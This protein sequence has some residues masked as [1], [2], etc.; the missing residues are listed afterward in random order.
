MEGEV[1]TRLLSID[2]QHR[3]AHRVEPRLL[4]R[5]N[6]YMRETVECGP[7]CNRFRRYAHQLAA[8]F[9]LNRFQKFVEA[10]RIEDVF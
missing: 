5:M 4:L 9:F 1:K 8:E 3:R 7:C 6:A 10:P 2:A